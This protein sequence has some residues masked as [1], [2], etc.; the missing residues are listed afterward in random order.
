MG[1]GVN[2]RQQRSLHHGRDREQTSH[3]EP[4]FLSG[5]ARRCPASPS[6][7]P[8]QREPDRSSR[9]ML[10]IDICDSV[11]TGRANHRQLL[12][13]ERMHCER[14]RDGVTEGY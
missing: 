3:I 4:S 13:A 14:H 11:S 1:L 8:L 7:C 2:R 5:D 10:D 12:P 6:I 9:R